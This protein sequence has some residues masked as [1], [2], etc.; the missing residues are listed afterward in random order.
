L[1]GILSNG[2]EN[3]RELRGRSACCY[4]RQ[5]MS[6]GPDLPAKHRWNFVDWAPVISL[7]LAVLGFLGYGT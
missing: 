2:N 4:M 5:A 3:G 6:S 7:V 1:D